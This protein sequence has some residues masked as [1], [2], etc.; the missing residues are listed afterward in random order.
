NS[1]YSIE[2]PTKIETTTT[3]LASGKYKEFFIQNH[4]GV[5]IPITHA[6]S[7][8]IEENAQDIYSLRPHTLPLLTRR[9]LKG[10]E[11]KIPGSELLV[12][13]DI[14]QTPNEENNNTTIYVQSHCG[15]ENLHSRVIRE[16]KEGT[17]SLEKAKTRLRDIIMANEALLKMNLYNLDIKLCNS[18]IHEEDNIERV[19]QIDLDDLADKHFASHFYHQAEKPICSHKIR[20]T[21]SN[22][23]LYA[24]LKDVTKDIK[25]SSKRRVIFTML[26]Q[27]ITY[28][29]LLNQMLP[30]NT[31]QD[32][33]TLRLLQ[34]KTVEDDPA[35]LFVTAEFPVKF[36]DTM[37]TLYEYMLPRDQA[38]YSHHIKRILRIKG[39]Y[40][41]KASSLPSNSKQAIQL[42]FKMIKYFKEQDFKL[43]S[44]KAFLELAKCYQQEATEHIYNKNTKQ[45][46][47]EN[48][49]MC[50][51]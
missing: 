12:I 46:L 51:A 31:I 47:K 29:N 50:I 4:K 7:K 49:D 16:L 44:S 23:P 37:L 11:Q 33:L 39:E 17:A 5:L 27:N 43:I 25:D 9:I 22:P 48:I 38:Y 13:P 32:N 30:K 18:V 35:M 41:K 1:I 20:E 24:L 28:L 45:L 8:K 21:F 34:N 26:Y 40:L 6:S 15:K 42:R 14:V 2:Y 19:L 3:P 10:V 36:L